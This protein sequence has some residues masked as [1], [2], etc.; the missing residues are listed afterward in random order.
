LRDFAVKDTAFVNKIFM[1]DKKMNQVTLNRS[2]KGV[3][4]LSDSIEVRHDLIFALLQTIHDIDI[5]APVP[6]AAHN[7]V[8]KQIASTGT[9]VEIWKKKYRINFFGLFRLFPY[10]ALEKTYYVG[11]PTQDHLGTFMIMENS[12]VAFINKVPYFR[13]FLSS[14]YSPRI[15]DWRNRKIFSYRYDEIAS[16]QIDWVGEPE[17]SFRVKCLGDF[18]FEIQDLKGNVLHEPD[19]IRI[20]DFITAFYNVHFDEYESG[21]YDWQ[22]DS[23]L[24]T[25]PQH[26]IT[27]TD[28][29]GNSE[30]ISTY[31]R[32]NPYLYHEVPE[33]A[34]LDEVAMSPYDLDRLY[35]H[36]NNGSDFVIIQYFIFDRILKKYS[37][38]KNEDVEVPK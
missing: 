30:R 5:V 6:R 8:I 9:K 1:A 13:G 22:I 23:V 25:S 18:R 16:V 21:F 32:E 14:R 2:D 7:N 31:L 33:D 29:K 35:A 19:S 20:Y 34:H 27:L 15:E 11:G 36:I 38:F 3:W 10:T 17:E 37:W 24:S 4:L 28:I 12:S 26:H